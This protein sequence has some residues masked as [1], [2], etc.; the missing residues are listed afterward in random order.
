MLKKEII[1]AAIRHKDTK[2]VPY[3]IEL[4]SKTMRSFAEKYNIQSKDFA[5]FSGNFIEKINYS[6]TKNLSDVLYQDDFNVVWKKSE[7]DDIGVVNEYLLREPDLKGFVF[8]EV[9][10]N[11]IYLK[12]ENALSAGNQRFKVGKIGTLLFERAWSLRGMPE[13]LMDFYDNPSFVHE[14][15]EKIT[16]YNIRVINAALAHDIDGFYFGD[17]YG[18]QTGL[19]MGKSLWRGFIMPYLKKTFGAVKKKNIPVILHS[20]G[21]II[22]ILP[23]LMDIGLD[24]YQTVQPEIYNLKELKNKFGKNLTFYGGISTN[25]MAKASPEEVKEK[26][27]GTLKIFEGN[28]GFI[29]APAHQ[30]P[31]DVPPE[32]VMAFI[33]IFKEK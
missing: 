31:F 33:E 10:I 15:F 21:N 24:V 16:E 12:T 29:C 14:L 20:C 23:D 4:C 26:I 25:F 7:G 6:G 3:N 28:G 1:S 18:Q 30:L 2:T 8:P 22:E 32:N 5:D 9:K 19:I 11:E 17:D 27:N 13:L